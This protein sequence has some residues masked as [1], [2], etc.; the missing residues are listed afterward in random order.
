M[1]YPTLRATTA[2][3][4]FK[5]TQGVGWKLNRHIDLL[6]AEICFTA[7]LSLLS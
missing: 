3:L 5:L 6:P 1:P 7:I 2:T 4:V